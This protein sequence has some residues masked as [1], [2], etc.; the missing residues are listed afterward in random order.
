MQQMSIIFP[1]TNLYFNH[2]TTFYRDIDVSY[3]ETSDNFSFN[4]VLGRK[5]WQ[6]FFWVAWL[7][8]DFFGY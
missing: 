1:Q 7:K 5:I 4:I 8:R 6:I 2:D 3:I